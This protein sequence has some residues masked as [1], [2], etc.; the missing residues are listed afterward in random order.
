M[1]DKNKNKNPFKKS[2]FKHIRNLFIVVGL[3]LLIKT[4]IV[5]V[6]FV[7]GHSMEPN[8]KEGEMI[9]IKKWNIHL[10]KKGNGIDHND[11][12]VL[13]DIKLKELDYT[14]S[15]VKRVVGLPG[16][17]LEINDGELY[18]NGTKENEPFINEKINEINQSYDIT[19]N[20]VFVMGDNRNHSTDSRHIGTQPIGN[21]TGEIIGSVDA[22]WIFKISEE[23][24]SLTH[25]KERTS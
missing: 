8:I 21:V 13:E 19:E 3:I 25:S 15:I 14:I 12:V 9:I 7:Y 22:K 23:I 17:H 16:D 4:F 20:Q 5:D 24:R 2:F 1:Y 10:G 6:G 11:T 18:R